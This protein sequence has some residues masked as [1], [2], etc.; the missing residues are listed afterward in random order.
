MR[1]NVSSIRQRL[2]TLERYTGEL[3]KQQKT[4]LA[5]LKNGFTSRLAVEH[6]SQAAIKGCLDIAAHI[7]S[8]Y[9]LGH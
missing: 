1:L 8:V 4:T 5:T 7:V 2:R 6:A 9:C 3:E